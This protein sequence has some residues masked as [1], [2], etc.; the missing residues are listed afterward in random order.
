MEKLMSN[1]KVAFTII[2]K[3]YLGQALTSFSYFKQIN[4]SGFSYKIVLMDML[5]SEDYEVIQKLISNG[6][7]IVFWGAIQN[8]FPLVSFYSMIRRYNVMEMNTAIK[9]YAI[10]HFY[11]HGAEKVSY[12]DPDIAFYGDLKELDKLLDENDIVLTPHTLKPYPEDNREVSNIVLNKAGIYNLGFIATKKSPNSMQMCEFWQKCLF[13]KAFARPDQGMFTDQKWADF[14]PALFS[15][16]LILKNKGY[17]AAYWNLHERKIH[18]CGTKYFAD[19]NELIF[20]HFSGLDPKNIEMISKHQNRYRLS[21]LNDDLTILFRDYAN[22]LISNGFYDYKALSY[23]FSSKDSAVSSNSI[24]SGN[25]VLSLS[26]SLLSKLKLASPDFYN[27]LRKY[28]NKYFPSWRSHLVKL[29]DTLTPSKKIDQI[30]NTSAK[31]GLNIYGYFE[32]HHSIAHVARKFADKIL[33]TGIPSTLINIGQCSQNEEFNVYR[34]RYCGVS[35]R[36]LNLFIVNLDQVPYVVKQNCI[37]SEKCFCYPFWEYDSGLEKFKDGL[38]LIDGIVVCSR[39][40]KDAINNSSD[41]KLSFKFIDYPFSSEDAAEGVNKE[42]TRKKYGLDLDDYIFFFNFDY[43]SSFDRKNPIDIIRAFKKA[44]NSNEKVRIVFKT[45]NSSLHSKAKTELVNF[46]TN[47]HLQNRVT[48]ID[49]FLMRNDFNELLQSCDAYISLHHG[50]GY[51]IGML[52]AMSY[53]LPV[54]ATNYSGNTE[55]CNHDTSL[56]VN[57]SLE[58][59]KDRHP[60]YSL[61]KTWAC[62]NIDC[63]AQHM[64]YLFDHQQEGAKLGEK[65][66]KFIAEKYSVYNFRQQLYDFLN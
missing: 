48:L 14:F 23:Y 52:E 18:K 8:D 26:N 24:S 9:P 35:N 19:D 3:N 25:K 45:S 30:P 6:V 56:L 29:N 43:N 27:L 44:F 51:G 55:F 13:D 11:K 28:G 36:F 37:N 53:S 21:D 31:F 16:V 62:P 64:R 2:S 10:E 47:N 17:N 49:T 34:Q 41:R 33:E 58:K 42:K 22:S 20:F 66:K 1:N 40:I 7:E 60:A 65:A 38:D 59:C 39:F 15:K 32:E 50:E 54:I 63:A 57:V 4:S 46:I 5:D 61:V 12:F